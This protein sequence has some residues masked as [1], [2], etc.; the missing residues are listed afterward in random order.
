MRNPSWRR[1]KLRREATS[2]EQLVWRKLRARQFEGYKFRRQH[3]VGPFVVDFYCPKHR[4]AIE[5]DGGGHFQPVVQDY[6]R[7]RT[8]FL[9]TCGVRVLRFTNDEV[10]LETAGVFE[11]IARILRSPQLPAG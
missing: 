6:D 8:H 3:E 4:L 10:F 1:R 2:A 7:R 5:L 11:F 9:R